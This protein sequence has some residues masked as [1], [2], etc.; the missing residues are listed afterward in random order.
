MNEQVLFSPIE[1]FFMN[2]MMLSSPVDHSR[3]M[4]Y[5]TLGYSQGPWSILGNLVVNVPC[6]N[7]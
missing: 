7:L 2:K 4:H 5:C 3:M 1:F 6:N